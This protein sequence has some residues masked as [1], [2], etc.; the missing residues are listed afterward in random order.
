MRVVSNTARLRLWP[1]ARTAHVDQ[2]PK[3]SSHRNQHSLTAKSRKRTDVIE[4]IRGQLTGEQPPRKYG[5]TDLTTYRDSTLNTAFQTCRKSSLSLDST[6]RASARKEKKPMNL[7]TLPLQFILL[8]V[9]VLICYAL[10]VLKL[11]QLDKHM[12]SFD[13]LR[14]MESQLALMNRRLSFLLRKAAEKQAQARTE[15]KLG[16]LQNDL[17]E[18]KGVTEQIC[19]KTAGLP[20]LLVG[21]AEG[22][23]L[24]RIQN[25]DRPAASRM[26]EAIVMRL[27]RLGYRDIKLAGDMSKV[28]FL[29]EV[30]VRVSATHGNQSCSGHVVMRGGVVTDV[31]I[32]V[33][34]PATT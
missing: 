8:F 14:E 6:R 10:V 18:L 21:N 26:V 16:D 30:N 7:S 1:S 5:L 13:G 4:T 33:T 3:P 11:R 23:S 34:K 20:E 27:R 28:D 19:N 22:E 32:G 2:H 25:A 17:Y 12:R 9:A 15:E 29:D 31:E 24:R